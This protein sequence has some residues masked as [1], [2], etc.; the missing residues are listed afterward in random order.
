[1]PLEVFLVGRKTAFSATHSPVVFLWARL[2][3]LLSDHTSIPQNQPLVCTCQLLTSTFLSFSELLFLASVKCINL[4]AGD[5]AGIE[6][7]TCA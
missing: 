3:E 2:G 6:R 7:L 1:M 4:T 5:F